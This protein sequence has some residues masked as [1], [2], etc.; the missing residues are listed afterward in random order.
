MILSILSNQEQHGGGSFS[1]HAVFGVAGVNG[2]AGDHVTGIGTSQIVR[3]ATLQPGDMILPGTVLDIAQN[4]AHAGSVTVSLG[5]TG[6]PA[7]ILAATD[8]KAAT[9]RGAF[10]TAGFVNNTA[11]PIDLIATVTVGSGN[12]SDATAG[13]IGVFLPISRR[14]ERS[15]ANI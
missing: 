8:V 11:S 3:I 7:G 4:Y 1:Q 12:V 5:Y 9:Q 13:R 10:A 14:T 2:Q 15:P 6:T